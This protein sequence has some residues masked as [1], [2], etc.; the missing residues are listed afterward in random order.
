MKAQ[1]AG[2]QLINQADS[3]MYRNPLQIRFNK[4]TAQATDQRL[5]PDNVRCLKALIENTR[6]LADSE[7]GVRLRACAFTLD[8]RHFAVLGG[9]FSTANRADSDAFDGALPIVATK[10]PSPFPPLQPE[11]AD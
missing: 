1:A 5:Y 2:A 6:Q 10:Q 4:D 9:A 7:I 8:E 3:P 11:P